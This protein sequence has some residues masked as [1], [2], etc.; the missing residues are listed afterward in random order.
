MDV[1]G[2]FAIQ[3]P[4][5]R[6]KFFYV[7]GEKLVVKG[8]TYGAFEPDAN[9]NEYRF[10]DTIERDFALM[11]EH[12]FIAVRIPHTMPPV[13][14][15]DAAE[16]HGLHVM[17]GLSAALEPA[18]GAIRLVVETVEGPPLVRPLPV[19][20][21][22]TPA[23]ARRGSVDAL[24]DGRELTLAVEHVRPGIGRVL[25][26]ARPHRSSTVTVTATDHSHRR[27]HRSRCGKREGSL[28]VPAVV[29]RPQDRQRVYS[30]LR[31]S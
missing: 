30:T 2:E 12:G 15:L 23:I 17:V 1:Q 13:S 8:P 31:L 29:G 10:H 7:G 6:G 11:V 4:Q 14:L 3:R 28:D 25:V 18:R 26:P 24:V 5:A 9:G 16:R 27:V 20:L 22:L 21:T 19:Q